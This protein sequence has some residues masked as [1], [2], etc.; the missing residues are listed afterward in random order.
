MAL[1]EFKKEVN[2]ELFLAVS[3]A[4]RAF[5]LLKYTESVDSAVLEHR[6]KEVKAQLDKTIDEV[7]GLIDIID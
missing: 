6:L 4:D 7:N 5:R 2:R 1:D 3:T